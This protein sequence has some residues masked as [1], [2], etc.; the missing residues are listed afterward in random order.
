MIKSTRTSF[1]FLETQLFVSVAV[2]LSQNLSNIGGGTLILIRP[3]DLSGIEQIKDDIFQNSV[4]LH[5]FMENAKNAKLINTTLVVPRLSLSISQEWTSHASKV[6][7]N[8]SVPQDDNQDESDMMLLGKPIHSYSVEK[9]SI[10][11]HCLP[12]FPS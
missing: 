2:P 5:A 10:N 6:I 12:A 7:G 1:N 9:I 4:Q 8:E 3:K 11:Y